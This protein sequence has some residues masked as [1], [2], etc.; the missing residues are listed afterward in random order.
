MYYENKETKMG[1]VVW[2]SRNGVT[3]FIVFEDGKE[4]QQSK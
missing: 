3:P 4:Y 2:N 1:F